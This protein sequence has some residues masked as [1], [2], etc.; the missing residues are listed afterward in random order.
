MWFSHVLTV[1]FLRLEFNE[2][3]IVNVLTDSPKSTAWGVVANNARSRW[4]GT[5]GTLDAHACTDL[6][7]RIN[8]LI[9]V[10]AWP[11]LQLDAR[12]HA[13]L[14]EQLKLLYVAITRARRRVFLFEA[15]KHKR[16]PGYAFLASPVGRD[17]DVAPP[18]ALLGDSPAARRAQSGAAGLAQA[19]S[20]QTWLESA[21][22]HMAQKEQPGRLQLAA[23]CFR[24]AGD[25]R[26]EQQALA[27]LA[28]AA[29]CDARAS[30]R[31]ADEV[32][33]LFA[34]A[35]C[36]FLRVGAPLQAADCLRS[37]GEQQLADALA[38]AASP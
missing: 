8:A 28:R 34:E 22:K 17:G 23:D 3:F 10:E 30:G 7:M 32:C 9:N 25:V 21:Q 13:A 18:V 14:A 15:N 20:A 36:G 35:A 6:R 29:A 1:R 19:S 26:G 5:C 27:E 12:A 4:D 16:G 33:A 37:A 2:V 38:A 31:D 11:P 24:N